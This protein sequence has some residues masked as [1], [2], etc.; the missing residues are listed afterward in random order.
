MPGRI[1]FAFVAAND[2]P[3]L[4]VPLMHGEPEATVTVHYMVEKLDAGDIVLQWPVPI[5]PA[6]SLHDLMVRSK[7]VG[8]QAVLEA[9]EQIE[10]GTAHRRP[11]VRM[12]A[13]RP[14]DAASAAAARSA[15]CRAPSAA[16]STASARS[17]SPTTRPPAPPAP[18]SAGG[19]RPC[20]AD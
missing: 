9:M 7:E 11:I 8:V 3:E 12:A 13:P 4:G 17:P 2:R 18:S 5:L 10:H 16:S 6:D 14:R 20:R 1:G 19:A 15:R